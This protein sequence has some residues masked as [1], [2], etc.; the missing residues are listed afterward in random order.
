[1][2]AIFAY[3]LRK[4]FMLLPPLLTRSPAARG[5]LSP[6]SKIS[7][8]GTPRVRYHSI[9]SIESNGNKRVGWTAVFTQNIDSITITFSPSIF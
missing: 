5:G 9:D 3:L 4:A 6:L 8:L 1:M 2:A 7:H